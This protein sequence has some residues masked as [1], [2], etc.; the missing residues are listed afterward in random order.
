MSIG[1]ARL[2][3]AVH[4]VYASSGDS[5]SFDRDVTIPLKRI[6]DTRPAVA[7]AHTASAKA[8][9]SP[10]KQTRLTSASSSKLTGDARPAGAKA[11]TVF[12]NA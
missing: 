2:A 12:A 11:R 4:T 1:G 10:F 3:V 5:K 7:R 9:G 6:S 8:Q